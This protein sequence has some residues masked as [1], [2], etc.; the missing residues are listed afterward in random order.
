MAKTSPTDPTAYWRE[1]A[2]VYVPDDSRQRPAQPAFWGVNSGVHEETGTFH[3]NFC[4]RSW[5]INFPRYDKYLDK[6]NYIKDA[7]RMKWPCPG[8]VQKTL[9]LIEEKK[10]E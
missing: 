8:C 9:V 3:C 5:I 6:I 1:N 4:M 7:V 10:Y 2:V